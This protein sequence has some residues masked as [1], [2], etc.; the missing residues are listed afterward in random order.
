[1][2]EE[3]SRDKWNAIYAFLIMDFIQILIVSLLYLDDDTLFVVGINFARTNPL[4]SA[5][6]F[7]SIAL[8]QLVLLYSS[9]AQMMRS[10]NLIELYPRFNK[11]V[12][13]R[14][15]YS[16]DS[17]VKWTLD[18]AKKSE[19]SV[20]KVYLMASPIPNAYTFSLPLLG[21]TVVVHSNTLE[22]L[23]EEE[24]QA[25]IAHELG[26]IKNRD[27]IVTIFVRMPSIFIDLIYLYIYVR[28]VLAIA[29]SLLV[30]GDLFSTA[31]RAVVLLAFFILSRILTLLS[32]Y[33]M[34][35]ASRAAE[36]M[37]DHHAATVL[38]HEATINSLIRL[39]QRVEAITVLVD[40][41]RW[42]ESL[43][44]E[45][46]GPISNAELMRMISQYPL[47]GIDE[48]NAREISPWVFLSTKL[49]HLREVYG[50]QLSDEQV[51]DA[52]EPTIQP[53]LKIRNDTKPVSKTTRDMNV[54]DWRKVDYDQDR[55]LSSEELAELLK[56]LRA[57]PKKM[58]F[59]SEVGVN[60]LN[61]DHPDFRRRVLFIA[62]EFGL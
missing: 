34:Q 49:R 35:R 30:D 51:K 24:M 20:D 43:N 45:R 38:G 28:L 26:H 14:R 2:I 8:M 27:S 29:D 13:W 41:I 56:L 19:V 3:V 12:P 17:I 5:A 57:Q 37:S 61:S 32:N 11:E 40:E 60:M 50:V 31:V 15:K 9:V 44:P 1:M 42:L 33:F 16:R 58:L 25:V 52:V 39:G 21:S 4:A 23:N 6:L 62:D 53:L 54:V 46:V 59:D 48:R 55:R 22:I 47:D 7:F 36:L 18:L 10:S